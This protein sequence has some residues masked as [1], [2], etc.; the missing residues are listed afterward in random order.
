MLE[1]PV[2]KGF[3][4]CKQSSTNKA[5]RVDGYQHKDVPNLQFKDLEQK[6]KYRRM[7]IISRYCF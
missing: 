6:N 3:G 1:Y 7:L 2:S 5:N 4:L